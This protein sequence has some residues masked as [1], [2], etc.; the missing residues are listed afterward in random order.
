[1][2]GGGVA[3]LLSYTSLLHLHQ[4]WSKKTRECSLG[5][6]GERIFNLLPAE[7]RNIDNH[8]IDIFKKKLDIFLTDIPDQPTTAR[9]GKICRFK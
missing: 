6:N 5:V 9:V 3:G 7:I 8:T 2:L 1:V 4:Q